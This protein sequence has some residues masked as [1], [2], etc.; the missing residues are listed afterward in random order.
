MNFSVDVISEAWFLLR[1]SG[2]YIL[3][4]LLV[5]GLSAGFSQSEH[6]RPT[7]W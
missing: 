4:G 3:F 5:S 1:E 7:P 2:L 6:D